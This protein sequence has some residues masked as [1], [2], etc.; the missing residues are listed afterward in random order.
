[1]N[2]VIA[3]TIEVDIVFHY[4][5]RFSHLAHLA[6]YFSFSL[7]RA[8]FSLG[9]THYESRSIKPYFVCSFLLSKTIP[10]VTQELIILSGRLQI[11]IFSPVGFHT[12]ENLQRNWHLTRL[13]S[14][15]VHAFYI[16]ENVE[17]L[18]TSKFTQI[19]ARNFLEEFLPL[20]NI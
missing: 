16:V 13:R 20:S 18:S 9:E 4:S 17:I 7:L 15:K 2:T 12:F 6:R 1:M 11:L 10:I 14:N 5:H 19:P 8:S 3:V